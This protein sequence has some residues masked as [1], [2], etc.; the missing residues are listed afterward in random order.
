M[1]DFTILLVQYFLQNILVLVLVLVVI[2]T[3]T[4]D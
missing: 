4:S 1:K 2:F 3:Y